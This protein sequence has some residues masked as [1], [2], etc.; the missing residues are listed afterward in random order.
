MESYDTAVRELLQV[1][2]AGTAWVQF[3]AFFL[4]VLCADFLNPQRKT[5]EPMWQQTNDVRNVCNV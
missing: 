5:D 2:L 4:L 1:F 3:A